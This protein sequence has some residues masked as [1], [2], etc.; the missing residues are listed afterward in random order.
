[1]LPALKELKASVKYF[2]QIIKEADLSFLSNEF[3]EIL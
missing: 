3:K 1:M 2:M